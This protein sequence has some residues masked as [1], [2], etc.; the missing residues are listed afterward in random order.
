[1]YLLTD[2]EL[3]DRGVAWLPRTLMEAV[4][5]VDADP[6][7]ARVLGPAMHRSFVTEKTGEW[8]S[9]HAW[10]SEWERDRYLRFF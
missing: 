7:A 8:N 9:Y 2:R 3:A 4:E 10:V 6:L 5:A 1:M